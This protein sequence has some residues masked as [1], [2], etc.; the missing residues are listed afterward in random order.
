MPETV[1][2]VLSPGRAAFTVW[3]VEALV[4]GRAE[5]GAPTPS[6]FEKNRAA[7][8]HL[9]RR[10]AED[11]PVYGVTTGFGDSCET[12][13]SGRLIRELPKN[14]FRFHGCGLGDPFRPD[15]TR[16][17]LLARLLSLASGYS[18]VRPEVLEN[19]SALFRKDI[20]PLIP[21]R[22]SVG[23]S[24]DLTPLSYIAAT[25]AGEATVLF[26]NEVREAS[27]VLPENG[28][29]LI[30]LEPKES[31]ALMNGT[32][33]MTGVAA[34]LLP[35]ALRLVRWASALTAATSDAIGGEPR[36]FDARLFDAKPHPGQAAVAGFIR[37]DLEFE[38]PRQFERF[39]IQDRYSIRCAPHVIGVLLDMLPTLVRFVEVELNGANDNPLI[40]PESGDILHGGNFYGGHVCSAMDTLKTLVANIADLLDR[41]LALLCNPATN[42]G[43]PANLVGASS[44]L[45]ASHHGFKAMQITA[46][47]L[48]AEALKLTMPASAFSRSTENHN[49][50]KVSMGTIAARDADTILELTE[51]V[52][53][54]LTL[55]VVQSY[56]LR[57]GQGCHQRLR[58]LHEFVR[59]TIPKHDSDR[60][61]QGD[62]LSVAESARRGELPFGSISADLFRTF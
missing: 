42:Q 51:Q 20:L 30:E 50:D 43:L 24:G 16:A 18:G 29:A 6:V 14:L 41:Q 54:I 7:R 36:H 56:D 31:L 22:G 12:K 37:E 26:A 21:T 23:A 34:L 58:T 60:P 32:S 33:A 62:I 27:A 5:L 2:E 19:L 38:R 61:M 4:F 46:S 28:L 15:Q 17:I 59:R 11:E 57:E 8:E 39:R 13:V 49:Q 40:D 45:A 44:E 47:A 9:A 55:A 53:G 25:L 48:T 35:R 52:A 3:D 10:L 1:M